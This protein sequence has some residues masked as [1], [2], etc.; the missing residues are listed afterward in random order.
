MKVKWRAGVASVN[1]GGEMHDGEDDEEN[2]YVRVNK[3]LI[4]LSSLA[5]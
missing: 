2:P 3:G 1:E 5:A 4:D